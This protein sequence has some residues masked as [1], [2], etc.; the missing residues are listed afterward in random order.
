MS[1]LPVAPDQEIFIVDDDDALRDSLVW[2]LESSGYK[3]VAFDSAEAF[4]HAWHEGLAGCLVLD[5]RMPGM[6]GLELFEELGRRR[7]TL[8]VIFITGH[9]DVPMAVAA[10]KKGAAD[11]IEKPFADREMLALIEHCLQQERAS[12][13]KRRQEAD[14]AR[15][16][17]HL[18]QRE[19]EVLDLIIAGK[20]NKQIAD[21]LGISIKTVEVHR[22]RVMEK[23]GA[24]SLA[25]LVQHVVTVEPA[26]SVR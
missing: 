11:F 12:R 10:L 24:H 20:L 15:R 2:M 9:G 6:S 7:C 4:L 5:V 14:T 1:V 8:P 19:R 13:D 22:A 17:E 21:V 16:L 25:E 26:A 3:V 18:T 23:M